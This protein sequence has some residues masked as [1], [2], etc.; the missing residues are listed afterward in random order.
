MIQSAYY[1]DGEI[2]KYLIGLINNTLPEDNIGAGKF[3]DS[4]MKQLGIPEGYIMAGNFGDKDKIFTI[5]KPSLDIAKNDK[6]LIAQDL[7]EFEYALKNGYYNSTGKEK[8]TWQNFVD[9]IKGK[10]FDSYSEFR[11]F[12]TEKELD[13]KILDTQAIRKR[14]SA[15]MS[16]YS[17]FEGY[18][19]PVKTYI[20]KAVNEAPE[21]LGKYIS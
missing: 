9:T 8:F 3:R 2:Y 1:T 11:S 20:L 7:F 18:K 17:T 5:Y 16:N 15:N 10:K 12:V 13:T 6:G 4:I 21:W 14:E 19:E